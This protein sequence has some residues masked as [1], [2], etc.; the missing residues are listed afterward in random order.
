MNRHLNREE[1]DQHARALIYAMR[2]D[3]DYTD[4]QIRRVCSAAIRQVGSLKAAMERSGG[5]ASEV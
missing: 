5:E 3:H 4:E 2:K 1:V